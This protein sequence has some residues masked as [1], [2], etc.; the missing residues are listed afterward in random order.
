MA[1]EWW[2]RLPAAERAEYERSVATPRVNLAAGPELRDAVL[3]I[4]RHLE[5]EFAAESLLFGGARGDGA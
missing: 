1:G 3:A 5:A 4:Q 2:R